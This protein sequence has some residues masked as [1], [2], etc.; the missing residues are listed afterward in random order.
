MAKAF[1]H[2]ILQQE[3]KIAIK[4]KKLVDQFLVNLTSNPIK[5]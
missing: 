2:T 5:A 4:Y 3:I 1:E